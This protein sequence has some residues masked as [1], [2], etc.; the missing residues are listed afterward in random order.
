[1]RASRLRNAQGRVIVPFQTKRQANAMAE[2]LSPELSHTA[3]ERASAR[4]VIDGR[5]LT[6]MFEGRDSTALRAIMSS[7]LRMLAAAMN[8]SNS[9]I[10]IEPPAQSK[11]TN[12][13]VG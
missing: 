6:L 8:V 7:Y 10:R 1:M 9:L 11:T 13:A 5:K 2:A 3:G 12:K 4:I